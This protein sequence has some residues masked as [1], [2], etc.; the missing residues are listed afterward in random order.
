MFLRNGWYVAASLDDLDHGLVARTILN[1]PIVLFR[2]QLGKTAALEDR[3]CH[4]GAPLSLGWTSEHGITC[5]YHGLEFDSAGTCV[6]VPG[7]KGKIPERAR[8]RSYPTSV[9]GDY[10]W[11]WMGDAGKADE[12]LIVNYPNEAIREWPREYDRLHIKASYLMVL[13]NLMDLSHLA[14]LH[15][16]S[17][18]GAP[19]DSARASMDVK[20]TPTGVKFLQ[21]M[22]DAQVPKNYERYN[23]QGKIDRWLE[24]EFVAPSCILQYSG[25]VD[26][27]TYDR[28]KRTGG[29]NLRVLHAIT[30]ETE[31]SC[32]YFFHT[33]N[34]NPVGKEPNSKS[35]TEIFAE[36]AH[37][38]EQQQQRLDGHDLSKLVDIPSDIARVQLV[39]FLN[40]KIQN[41]TRSASPTI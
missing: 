10:V 4:R 23:Y 8:V 20:S 2:D 38:L 13:E 12:A 36:D 31:T 18:G 1:E 11:I 15:K 17:I 3:C 29:H 30:P 27:G 5:G 26:A 40:Q 33:S 22:R 39:R 28:G 25:A 41:E 34:G 19:D 32:H 9:K 16:G 21:L 37:M 24:F 14:Y 6:Q 35:V 7:S